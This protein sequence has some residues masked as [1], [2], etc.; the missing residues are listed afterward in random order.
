MAVPGID[1]HVL[2]VFEESE[3]GRRYCGSRTELTIDHV[4]PVSKGGEL[5]WSNCVTACRACNAKKGNKTLQQLGWTP[6]QPPRVRCPP[7]P[8]PT[9]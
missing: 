9:L 6:K 4:L 2:T 3:W 8:P 5:S 1:K 7:P